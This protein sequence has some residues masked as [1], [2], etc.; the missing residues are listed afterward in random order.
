M[1]DLLIRDVPDDVIVAVDANAKR[2]GL[3]RS[4]FVRRLLA[5][6][7]ALTDARPLVADDF[8]RLREALPD[9]DDAEIMRGA[10]E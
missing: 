7:K 1:P 2:Q 9:L 10:W 6:Q 3:S 5:Q 4:E 8:R